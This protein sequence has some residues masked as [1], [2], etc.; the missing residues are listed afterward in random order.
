MRGNPGSGKE[1]LHGGPGET[2]IYLLLDILIRHGIIHALHADMVVVVDGCHFPDCQLERCG[3]EGQ[4]E[5][6]FLC[7]EGCQAAFSLLKWLVVK[8]SWTA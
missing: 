8:I 2:Y 7:K 4:Q 3:R 6:F 5:Q 1:Y